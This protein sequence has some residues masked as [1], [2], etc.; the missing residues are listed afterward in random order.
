MIK[1]IVK[2]RIGSKYLFI[3]HFES[4]IENF[5]IIIFL[6]NPFTHTDTLI[7]YYLRLLNNFVIN[8]WHRLFIICIFNLFLYSLSHL[9][10]YHLIYNLFRRYLFIFFLLRLF[11][12]SLTFYWIL[13][14]WRWRRTWKITMLINLIAFQ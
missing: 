4:L 3:L 6:F 14:A 1:V 10:K 8:V 2:F 9:R 13:W 12:F 5:S 7:F 11:Y